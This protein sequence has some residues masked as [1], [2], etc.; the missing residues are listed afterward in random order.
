MQDGKHWVGTWAASPAPA[1]GVAGFNNQ[2]LRMMP[3]VSLGGDTIRVRISNAYGTRPLS[4]GAVHVAV[5]DKGPNIVAGTDRVVPF[6]GNG[7]VTVAAGAVAL[8]DPVQLAVAPLA[9]LAVSF[10]LPGEV[11]PAL[12]ITGRYARQTNYVSPPG[13]YCGDAV[14]PVGNLTDQW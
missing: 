11:T 2:T 12:G 14:M 4:V 3:R 7:A 8:S 10:H 6:D 9:D 5:R 1:E 13:N